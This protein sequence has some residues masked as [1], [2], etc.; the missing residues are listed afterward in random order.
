MNASPDT[1]RSEIRKKSSIFWESSGQ[2]YRPE[3]GSTTNLLNQPQNEKLWALMSSYIPKDQET[4]QKSIVNHCEYTLARTR[5]TFDK[6]TAYMAAAYSL[7]DRL[8]ESWND[9]QQHITSIDPKRVYYFSLEYLIGRHMQNALLNIDMEPEYKEA[10]AELGFKLE[11]LYEEEHDPGLGNGGLGRLAACFMDSLATL[12]YPA[13]GYGI[14]YS[15]GIF[16]QEIVNGAQVEVPDYW[17]ANGNPFEIE[18]TDIKFP[19]RFYGNTRKDIKDGKEIS[20]WEGGEVILACAFDNPIPGYNTFNTVNLR[21]WK[22][23]PG[24]EFD[25]SSFNQGDYFKAL[26]ARQRAEYITS[27]LYPNDSTYSGKELRLKQQYF[28]CCAS[29]QDILRRFKKKNRDW[30]QLP[31][32][33]AIQLN[34]THPALAVV[35]LLRIL[36]DEEYLDTNFSMELVYKVFAYTNHTVLPEALEKWSVELLSNLLPRHLEIMYLLNHYFLEKMK[37]KALGDYDKLRVLS[38]VEE[39]TPKMIKMANL[40]IIGSHAV[41]GVAE[42]H[43]K[44]LTTQLFKEFYDIFPTKF[45]NKTNG[46]TPRR[47]IAVAN[48]ELAALY[49][50]HVNNNLWLQNL[51]YLRPLVEKAKDPEFQ[52]KWAQI[53][54]NNKKKLAQWVFQ[55]CKIVVNENSLFDVMVKR[56]HEYK[57]QLMNAFYIIHRYLTLKSLSPDERAKSVPRTCFFGGKAAPGYLQAKRIIKL[58]GGISNTINND[59]ETNNYLKCIFMPNYNV[60]NAQ[61]IIPAAELNQHISTAGTEAS[62]TSNMKFVMNGGL[63]IGTMDGANVEIAQEVGEENM[64]IFGARVEEIEKLREKMR[65]STYEEYLGPKLLPVFQAI[66]DGMFGNKEEMHSLLHG[67]EDGRDFYLIC[68]DFYSYCQAQEK[69]DATYK[70]KEEWTRRSIIN[71]VSSSKFSSDRTIKQYAQ[72]IWGIEPVLIPK[73]ANTALNRLKESVDTESPTKKGD[74]GKSS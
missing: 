63:I 66:K 3:F 20:V 6:K 65:N 12:D 21:L 19:V 54:M 61:I 72:E 55:R 38:L 60:S 7:R 29:I 42:L 33:V 45:Q 24:T 44:L 13:W 53:K 58:I 47:W 43:S 59:K 64:F 31:E 36:I 51:E 25:F 27:V 62:G 32:K 35:E 26:E 10:L 48:P 23:V 37:K 73:P 52:K 18:R 46:V 71:A 17:L 56:I 16:K 68:H 67:L 15:Y 22:S 1:K 8:I 5:F 28:F 41:N 69:V 70:N 14:R 4:I 57:R 2:L 40:C 11:E 50:E 30:K 9:T 39:S 74:N 34:D 49:N